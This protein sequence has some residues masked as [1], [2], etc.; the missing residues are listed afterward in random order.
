[1]DYRHGIACYDAPPKPSPTAEAAV[2]GSIGSDRLSSSSKLLAMWVD[3]FVIVS[4]LG[5]AHRNVGPVD[6][7]HTSSM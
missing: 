7:M 1:M 5:L 4:V 2:S 6:Q 3:N